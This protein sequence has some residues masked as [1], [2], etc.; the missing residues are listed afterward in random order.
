MESRLHLWKSI[1]IKF[2]FG[3]SVFF[4]L[5]EISYAQTPC[6]PERISPV[7]NRIAPDGYQIFGPNYQPGP[8]AYLTANFESKKMTPKLEIAL[9]WIKGYFQGITGARFADYKYSYLKGFT[10]EM[11][12]ERNPWY[13]ASNRLGS[14][15]LRILSGQTF[16][17]NGRLG[18]YDGPS[19][20]DINFNEL[21]HLV[22]PVKGFLDEDGI[23]I[24]YLID[25]KPAFEIPKITRSEGNIDYYQFPGPPPPNTVN[26]SNWEFL[27]GFVIRKD[28]KP[29][30]IPFTR[31]EVL[32]S[33]L[34]DLEIIYKNQ[35]KLA[36]EFT[37]VIPPEEFDRQLEERI[38]EIKKYTHEGIWGY[39]KENLESRI[40]STIENNRLRKEE[41]AA[42]LENALAELNQDYKTAVELI[43]DYL[44]SQPASELAK[45]VREYFPTNFGADLVGRMIENFDKEVTARDW[46]QNL[47]IVYINPDYFDPKLSPD[48]PQMIAVEFVNLEGIHK[49]LNEVVDRI[50]QKMDFKTLQALFPPINMAATSVSEP[51]K[52]AAKS[53]GRYLDKLEELGPDPFPATGNSAAST[54]MNLGG[55]GFIA[56]PIQVKFPDRSPSLDQLS[57]LA[58]S[59]F[60]DSYLAE[61]GRKFLAQLTAEQKGTFDRWIRDYE[62]KT[63]E[64]FTQMSMLS[65]TN[66]NPK[67]S[68]YLDF[69]AVKRFPSSGLAANNLAVHLLKSGYPEKS[70]PILNYWLKEFP[71]N[72]LLLGNA[73]TATYYLGD[74]EKAFQLAKRTVEQ[75]SLHPNANKILAF[76]HHRK[77]EKELV[78]KA[79]ER[80]LEGSYDEEVVALLQEL[81]PEAPIGKIIYE[82]RKRPY[83]PQLMEKFRMPEA[84][85]GIDDAESQA[86]AIQKVLGSI[87][88]TMAAINK[89]SSEA[90]IEQAARKNIQQVMTQGGI[91]IMQMLAQAIYFQS[92]QT[93]QEDYRREKERFFKSLNELGNNYSWKVNNITKGYDSEMFKIEGG[94]DWEGERKLAELAKAKCTK[95]NLALDEYYMESAPLINQMVIRLELMSRDHHSTLSY[96]APIWLQSNEAADF[97][98]IQLNYLRD[99][100]EILN[101]YPIGLPFDCERFTIKE[102]EVV[103]GTLMVWEDQYCPVKVTAGVG[104]IKGGINCNTFSLSGGEFLVGE[105]ELKLNRDW[106][107]IEE[108]T[109][110]AGFGLNL[111]IGL[112]NKASKTGAGFSAE[113]ST[114]GFVKLSKDPKSMEWNF[115]NTDAGIKTEATVGGDIG[116][117]GVEVKLAETSM[118]FRSGITSDG[119]IPKM[120]DLGLSN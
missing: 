27:D 60:Y 54:S 38:A 15:Y 42:K 120:I 68:I 89:T 57:N 74:V 2:L 29:L 79:A 99:M 50:N 62:L 23:E 8:K 107:S 63:V 106:D 53:Q 81:D 22:R 72:S 71:D 69:E 97:P 67:A 100:R 3:A 117:F 92:L 115:R 91:P 109:V 78:K 102:E 110:G 95:L 13:L 93:Y 36:L 48:I 112:K 58:T 26:Y 118:G 7:W 14:Y 103:K 70:L 34:I 31:K 98:V 96:W 84:I 46:G 45:P 19:L 28:S 44:N 87:E 55:P 18:E 33:K 66:S 10:H 4:S 82:G 56:A 111:D 114:K 35:K 6:E 75:D 25:G 76:V 119:M 101:Q 5:S 43:Q 24:L 30:F 32:E 83:T 21:T 52:M 64:E 104:P 41:E 85:Q 1:G 11:E 86:E 20:I 116:R 49:H 61:L 108:V 16:C 105:V 47:E 94:A 39:S 65:W 80:S 88:M 90:I 73:A 40:Q 51:I 59:S 37:Q 113:L 17:S 77:G 12:L 9:S